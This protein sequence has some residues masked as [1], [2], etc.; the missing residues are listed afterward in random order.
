MTASKYVGMDM[1]IDRRHTKQL[2]VLDLTERKGVAKALMTED[3]ASAEC[4]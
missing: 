2:R 4:R 3:R 1:T